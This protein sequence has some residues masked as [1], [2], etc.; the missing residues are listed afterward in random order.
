MAVLSKTAGR[1]AAEEQRKTSM[2][3]ETVKRTLK[4]SSAK[5]GAVLL[6]VIFLMCIFANFIA[7][8]DVN[9]MDILNTYS[10]PSSQHIFGTDS[11]GRDLFTR[12]LY[13][14]RYSL[15]LG[16]MVSFIHLAFG[17]IVGSVAGYFGG[18]VESVIMRLMDVISALPGTLLAIII[19]GAL[20]SGYMNTVLAM[21]VGGLPG[22]VRMQRGQ[23]LSQR[24]QEYVEAAESINCSKVSIMFR[25]L[26]P[27]T[28][29]P[30]IISFTMGIGGSITGA[31]GLSFIGLGVQPP[32][33]EWGALLSDARAHL[34]QYPH[35]IVAPG[36]AIALTILG[37][38]LIGDG[39][40]DALDPK[41]RK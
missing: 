8:Y 33:P 36:I 14:G 39:L 4:S 23:I 7:P 35:L 18:V 27:N 22:G 5:F 3:V 1:Q 10:K 2:L 24:S 25:H 38:N 40:R 30:Q 26:L 9:D 28:F 17:I 12:I 37:F 34:L 41:L 29:A 6:A 31:A 19:S 32:T 13:G 11:L 20:G 21:S 16:L 15:A